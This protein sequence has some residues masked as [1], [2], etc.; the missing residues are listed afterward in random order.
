[1]PVYELIDGLD[2]GEFTEG[3]PASYRISCAR[4]LCNGDRSWLDPQTSLRFH[5]ELARHPFQTAKF[6]ASS[7]VRLSWRDAISWIV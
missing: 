1:M 7:R 3:P 2:Q 6:P 5:H 4:V